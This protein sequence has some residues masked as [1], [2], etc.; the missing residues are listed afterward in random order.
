MR[1]Y[2]YSFTSSNNFPNDNK[3]PNTN[4]RA[5]SLP[6]ARTDPFA[7]SSSLPSTIRITFPGSY[8]IPLH[9]A[10]SHSNHKSDP[11]AITTPNQQTKFDPSLSTDCGS[12]TMANSLIDSNN[13]IQF[14]H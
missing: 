9:T 8:T 6:L 7:D 13:S 2:N 1:A 10:N 12:D 5:N 4:I 3:R 11:E 14:N